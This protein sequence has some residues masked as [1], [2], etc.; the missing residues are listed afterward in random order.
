MGVTLRPTSGIEAE[1][2]RSNRDAVPRASTEAFLRPLGRAVGRGDA[3]RARVPANYDRESVARRPDAAGVTPG[4]NGESYNRRPRAA[5][6]RLRRSSGR[7]AARPSPPLFRRAP[8]FEKLAVDR[9][10]LLGSCHASFF[11]YSSSRTGG[12]R[13]LYR[14]LRV[15]IH[16][17]GVE[18]AENEKI[19]RLNR[20]KK[21]EECEKIIETRK[22]ET[23]SGLNC[24]KPR[25]LSNEDDHG[26][27]KIT[28][29]HGRS[30]TIMADHERSR[31][32]GSKRVRQLVEN[33]RK[34]LK[35][36]RRTYFDL[37]IR[38]RS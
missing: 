18:Y 21:A 36:C 34:R 22:N 23:G 9:E 5:R 3:G 20:S 33:H 35:T 29:E 19:K 14:D 6:E 27:S 15:G 4:R 1:F 32:F 24:K 7:S 31:F 28:A 8:S 17:A 13:R 25:S 2:E 30:R 38:D 16:R 12:C 10:T 37:K 26:R 11:L